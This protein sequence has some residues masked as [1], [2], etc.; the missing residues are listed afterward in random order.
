MKLISIFKEQKTTG[1][2]NID[3]LGKFI[4]AIQN[5]MC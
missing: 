3:F 5:E 2:L 4:R 1:S